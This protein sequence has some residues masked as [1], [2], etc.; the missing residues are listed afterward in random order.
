MLTMFTTNTCPSDLQ[1]WTSSKPKNRK[2]FQ[3]PWQ[4]VEIYN[5]T[6][7]R[8]VSLLEE[9]IHSGNIN[10]PSLHKFITT[11]LHLQYIEL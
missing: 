8:F 10:T 4:W 2:R 3:L 1:V 5:L 6:N 11:R 7:L 9:I